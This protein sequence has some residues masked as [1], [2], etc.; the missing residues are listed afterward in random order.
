MNLCLVVWDNVV[1]D[2]K[3]SVDSFSWVVSKDMKGVC[4]RLSL[5]FMFS[6]SVLIIRNLCLVFSCVVLC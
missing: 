4:G 6:V 2:M 1:Y 3:C 5:V